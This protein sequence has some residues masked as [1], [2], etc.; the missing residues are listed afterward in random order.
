MAAMPVIRNLVQ[1]LFGLAGLEL[2]RTSPSVPAR[3]TQL[4]AARHLVRRGLAVNTVIDIGAGN[5]TPSLRTAFPYVRHLLVEPLEE[6]HPALQEL[7]S[8]MAD[9]VVVK[10]AAG[11]ASGQVVLNV[12]PDLFG[13]S[14]LKE[15]EATDVNGFERT[16]RQVTVDELV[17]EV[18]ATPP[19]LLKID[20]QGYELE[21]LRG[22][23]RVLADTAVILLEVSLFQFFEGGPLLADVVEHLGRHGFVVYDIVDHAYRPLDGALAQVD[24]LFVPEKG[25]LRQQHVYATGAQRDALTREL[26]A[27]L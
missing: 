10:A 2:H 6:F 21:V 22:S 16:V 14:P 20:T 17:G 27:T 11:P 25:P 23:E 9:A 12:H 19:Y 24:M 26:R 13:S 8:A 3:E 15:G 4:G 5:G 18:T 1:R 7:A